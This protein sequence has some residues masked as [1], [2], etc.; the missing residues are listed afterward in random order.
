MLYN[1]FNRSHSESICLTNDLPP[2]TRPA[3]GMCTCIKGNGPV[4]WFLSIC[5]LWKGTRM[6][7]VQNAQNSTSIF[8]NHHCACLGHTQQDQA[9][10]MNIPV[11]KQMANMKAESNESDRS[12]APVGVTLP[13]SLTSMHAGTHSTAVPLCLGVPAPWQ[14]DSRMWSK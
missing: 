7:P 9:W 8:S 1:I 2:K 4:A 12:S 6:T 11:L 3:N 14:C 5:G 10:L 13:G